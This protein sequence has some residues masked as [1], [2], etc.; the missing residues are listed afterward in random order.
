M[1]AVILALTDS[2][3]RSIVMAMEHDKRLS[4]VENQ[5]RVLED[6]IDSLLETCKRLKMENA[7]LRDQQSSLISERAKLIEKNESAKSRVESIV[8]RLRAME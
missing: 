1:A 8:N 7:I 2:R 4:A 6:R 5:I 3:C